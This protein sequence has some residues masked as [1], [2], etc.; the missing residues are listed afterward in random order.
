LDGS[1]PDFLLQ[2]LIDQSYSLVVSR[3]KRG[4][5]ASLA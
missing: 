4:E 5:Q 1:I 2:H 3:L